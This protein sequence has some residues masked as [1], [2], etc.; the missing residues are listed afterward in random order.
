MIERKD[1]ALSTADIAGARNEHLKCPPV[2][3]ARKPRL[4]THMR[5]YLRL[6]KVRNSVLNGRRFRP[7]SWMNRARLFRMQTVL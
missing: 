1:G 3:R 2:R 4:M 7:G 5:L 6:R